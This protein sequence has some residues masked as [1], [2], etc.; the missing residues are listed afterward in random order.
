MSLEQAVQEAQ[1]GAHERRIRELEADCAS[2]R[3]LA[4]DAVDAQLELTG[5]VLV[6][7]G[8]LKRARARTLQWSTV[9]EACD[10]NCPNSRHLYDLHTILTEDG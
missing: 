6:L 4:A 7:E 9:H 5:R 1:T 2:L 8:R 10:G 3:K